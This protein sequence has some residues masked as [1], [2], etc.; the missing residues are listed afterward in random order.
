MEDL[1]NESASPPSLEIRENDSPLVV[2]LA[3][4]CNNLFLRD[5]HDILHHLLR[6]I[7][8]NQDLLHR[9]I[10]DLLAARSQRADKRH[11]EHAHGARR[12]LKHVVSV[13]PARILDRRE[14]VAI[15]GEEYDVWHGLERA[16]QCS[17]LDREARPRVREGV[18]RPERGEWDGGYDELEYGSV[19]HLS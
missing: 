19:V 4:V 2:T 7:L 9:L 15:P 13:I 17:L 18:M 1:K 12:D 10:H 8:S 14:L 6:P 5:L 11:V 3:N 16:E